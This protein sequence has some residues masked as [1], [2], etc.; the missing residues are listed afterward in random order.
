MSSKQLMRPE[1]IQ[2]VQRILQMHDIEAHSLKLEITESVIMENLDLA[3]S[4]LDAL[5][6]LGTQVYIDDFGTGYSSFSYLQKLPVDALKI[7]RMFVSQIGHNAS[8]W[9][10][11]QSIVTL[12]HAL[13]LKVVA[14]GVE[15]DEQLVCLRGLECE[16]AQGYVIGP[17]VDRKAAEELL[18]LEE[19]FL[20]AN[21]SAKEAHL[22]IQTQFPLVPS[23]H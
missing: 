1:F 23:N 9:Q 4:R 17:P 18:R 15:T 19:K 14:E 12:A 3:L 8:S 21:A 22:P 13:G 6:A 16:F 7:D 20:L 2:L 5:H 11:V 10:I